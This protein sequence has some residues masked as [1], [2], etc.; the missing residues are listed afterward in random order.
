MTGYNHFAHFT[1]HHNGFIITIRRD[2]TCGVYE[3]WLQH[4]DFGISTHLFTVSANVY[5]LAD[6]KEIVEDNLDDYI[7]DYEMEYMM[8]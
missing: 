3:A 4:R 1:Y 2:F 6:C 7:E 8:N 5:K